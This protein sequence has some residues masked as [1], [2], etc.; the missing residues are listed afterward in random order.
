MKKEKCETINV[1]DMKI[2]TPIEVCL[3]YLHCQ[4]RTQT[5]MQPETKR[6]TLDISNLILRSLQPNLRTTSYSETIKRF[7]KGK[8][9][10]R[11]LMEN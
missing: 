1:F 9:L 8:N 7:S 2:S 4:K 10:F 3:Y 6:Q 5:H 11:I